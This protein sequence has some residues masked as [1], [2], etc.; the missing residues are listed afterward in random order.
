MRLQHTRALWIVSL[1]GMTAALLG[2]RP[3]P[4][5]PG[6]QAQTFTP[7]DTSGA[8]LFQ[9][10]CAAC[11]GADGR[12]Q[13]PTQLGFDV[14]PP[15][16]TDCN[17]ASREPDGDWFA[18]IHEG[19]PARAF[20][21]RMPALGDALTDDQIRKVLEHVREFCGDAGWP[22][23]ELN[24]PRALG[25][26]KAYPEDEA[27]ITTSVAAEGPGS[28]VTKLL[29]EKRFGARSQIELSLPI[30]YRD[31]G[32]PDG[33]ELGAGDIGIGV[34]HAL[35]HSLASGTIF[36][37]GG[38]V[39]LPTGDEGRGF[40]KGTTVLEPYLAFGQILPAESFVQVQAL[41]EFPLDRDLAD[42]MAW[43]VAVGRTW[44]SGRFG[45]A[46]TPMVGIFGARELESGADVNWDLV[47]QFQ[48][49]LSTRQ[50]VMANLGVRLPL[51]NTGARD[52]E[53]LFYILWDWFDGGFF[54]GW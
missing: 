3:T 22:R 50:H 11:H 47:P 26:E 42:E 49:T 54:D 43:R 25:I 33:W 45:R 32:A 30:G 53:V 27:V 15:D 17:F 40:G 18:I 46:W 19:G 37:L 34:K 24:L 12:G 20:S 51:N 6:A 21:E 8:R 44:S 52:T 48:V 7:P 28:V 14:A 23:G 31:V 13:P 41:A 9:A 1:L 35:F 39:V 16:F 4:G 36:T 29:Y 38:E 10:S 5:V 2:L